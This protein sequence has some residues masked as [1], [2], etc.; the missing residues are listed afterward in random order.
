[1]VLTVRDDGP[2]MDGEVLA[3][4]REWYFTTKP[5]GGMGLGFS[6]VDQT[7][8]NAG[9]RV[10][11]ESAPGRGTAVL[12]YLP[13]APPRPPTQGVVLGGVAG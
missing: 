7:V 6:L 2:G 10:E 8:R 1:V 4:C 3:R 11:V 12:L 13:A 9:G 5:E